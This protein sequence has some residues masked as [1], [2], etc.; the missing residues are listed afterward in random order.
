MTTPII[1]VVASVIGIALLLFV[2]RRALRLAVR[3]MFVGVIL[4]ALLVGAVVWWWNNG[5]GGANS[6]ARDNH[7]GTTRRGNSR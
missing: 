3:L 2:L 7:S 4:L 5:S 6:P 1:A